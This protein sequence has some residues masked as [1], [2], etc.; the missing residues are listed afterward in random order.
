MDFNA[1]IGTP[2]YATGDGVVDRADAEAAGYGSH[3]VINHGFGYQTLYGHMSKMLV[4]PG[5][6]VKRGEIIGLV[7]N[8]GIS[9]GPHVH[10]EVIR[11]GDKVNP[12]NYY[13]LDL[14]PEEYLKIIEQ[15]EQSNQSFD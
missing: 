5:Q 2:I 7:G 6:V 3:V 9:S 15:S 13:F 12:V 11:N 14:T 1:A 8:S 4:K 10:Y